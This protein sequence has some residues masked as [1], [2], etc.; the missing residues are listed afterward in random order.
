[1]AQTLAK[2]LS[3]PENP[4]REDERLQGAQHWACRRKLF[5]RP[6]LGKSGNVGSPEG[7]TASLRVKV[8]EQSTAKLWVSFGG[9]RC[10]VGR[11][12]A[13]Q[14][15]LDD[16]ASAA[17]EFEREK[18]ERERVD[19]SRHSR[20]TSW[21]SCTPSVLTSGARDGVRTPNVAETLPPVGHVDGDDVH[22]ELDS[23]C[24]R[25]TLA[26]IIFQTVAN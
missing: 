11:A 5:R 26:L 2:V 24:D 12:Q 8:G 7:F 22:L 6:D 18:G 1:M 9:R 10:S 14:S 3:Y 23:V 13:R 20:A 4:T 25:G 15:E 21:R 16:G 19:A 17:A